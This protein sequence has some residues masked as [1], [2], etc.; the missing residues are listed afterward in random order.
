M[1]HFVNGH[2]LEGQE[3]EEEEEEEVQEDGGWEACEVRRGCCRRCGHGHRLRRTS[4]P[5]V[6]G[7][8]CCRA[9]SC[10]LVASAMIAANQRC[11]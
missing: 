6:L 1:S 10:E 11:S 9:T 3:E 8:R 4:Q 5:F 2:E 7:E